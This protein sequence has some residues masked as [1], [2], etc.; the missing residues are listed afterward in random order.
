MCKRDSEEKESVERKQ[1]DLWDSHKG[2]NY[3]AEKGDGM[4]N[5]TPVQDFRLEKSEQVYPGSCKDKEKVK[6]AY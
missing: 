6:I 4:R 5:R 3:T 2:Q 1:I